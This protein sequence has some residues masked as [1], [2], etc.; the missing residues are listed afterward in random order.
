MRPASNED[1][2]KCNQMQAIRVGRFQD[3]R[4]LMNSSR[5]LVCWLNWLAERRAILMSRPP[6]ASEAAVADL[7]RSDLP[8]RCCI[9]LLQTTGLESSLNLAH[10][11]VRLCRANPI[12]FP[13]RQPQ[14]LHRVEIFWDSSSSSSSQTIQD[15]PHTN[16]H[17]H[18]HTTWAP[19]SCWPRLC[20]LPAMRHV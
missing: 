18:T 20:A 16:K 12:W 5:L 3:Y 9:Y 15:P 11:V 10:K 8:A 14:T 17:T 4:L 7:I 6:A 1:S 13:R 2:Q 19:V